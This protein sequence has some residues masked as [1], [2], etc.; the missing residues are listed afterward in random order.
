MEKSDIPHW[1][2][3]RKQRLLCAL[4]G[5]RFKFVRR[6]IEGE[7]I[8]CCRRCSLWLSYGGGIWGNLGYWED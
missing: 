2:K 8:F 4:L 3:T 6:N 7:K 5:H 1:L